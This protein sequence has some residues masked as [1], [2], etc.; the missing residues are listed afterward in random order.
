MVYL[1]HLIFLLN[2]VAELKD[3]FASIKEDLGVAQEKIAQLNETCTN[4]AQE[5]MMLAK[6]LVHLGGKIELYEKT[7]NDIISTQ[8]EIIDS[9]KE[10]VDS[11][12]LLGGLLTISERNAITSEVKKMKAILNI[13]LRR[14]DVVDIAET[15]D[16]ML[17]SNIL[18]KVQQQCPTIANI[19]EQL[20]LSRN[21][22]RNTLKTAD[23]KMKAS[24]HLLASLMDV[25]DQHAGNDFPILF[26]LLCLCYGAGPSM[27]HIMQHLGLSESFQVL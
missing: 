9:Y 26:G 25:R 16:P 11:G 10:I 22:T 19:L 14:K 12:N 8:D 3:R 2:C 23:M 20:V 21:T 15:F 24:I 5:K 17:F 6:H 1:I 7:A 13:G 27:I 4:L 18:H